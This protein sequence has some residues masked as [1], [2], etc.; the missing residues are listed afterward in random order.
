M[1]IGDTD[2]GTNQKRFGRGCK[3]R[4]A[5]KDI[6]LKVYKY[7]MPIVAV[8]VLLMPGSKQLWHPSI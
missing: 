1:Y 8:I 7:I 2:D 3:P 5:V 6:F 4:P